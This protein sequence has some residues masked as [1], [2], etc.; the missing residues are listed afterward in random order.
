ME[1][2]YIATNSRYFTQ[3][4]YLTEYD[5]TAHQGATLYTV[6]NTSV[7][8]RLTALVNYS[9]FSDWLK[10]RVTISAEYRYGKTP[11]IIQGESN[12][13]IRNSGNLRF[14]VLTNF[15]R[16][17]EFSLTSETNLSHFESLMSEASKILKEELKFDVRTDFIPK[18][19]ITSTIRYKLEKEI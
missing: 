2:N 6:E 7:S 12:T 15:S 16:K 14:N 1:H 18:F 3:D 4:T 9:K 10:S 19:H 17:I 13:L 11:A 8:H 5:Y